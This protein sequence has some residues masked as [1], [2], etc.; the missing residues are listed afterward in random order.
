M[1]KRK[2][3]KKKTRLT[4]QYW[5]N[6]LD[7]KKY[8]SLQ[9]PTILFYEIKTR[10]SVFSGFLC[11]IAASDFLESRI[12]KHEKVFENRLKKISRLPKTGA[13]SGRACTI[14]A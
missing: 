3:A 5:N 6:F 2:V 9:E 11:G 14:S 8:L 1:L 7:S 10:A 4:W 12:S 13:Y